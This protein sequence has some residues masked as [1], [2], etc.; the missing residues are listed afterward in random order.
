MRKQE[1]LADSAKILPLDLIC[2]PAVRFPIGLGTGVQQR[3]VRNIDTVRQVG[4]HEQKSVFDLLGV[5]RSG[6]CNFAELDGWS[7][8]WPNPG[9]ISYGII[10][11]SE[12]HLK[13]EFLLLVHASAAHRLGGV[14]FGARRA[15][16][17]G[18]ELKPLH[19]RKSGPPG[20]PHSIRKAGFLKA[21]CAARSRLG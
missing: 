4:W 13:S 16:V 6:D 14:R 3:V 12:L 9:R 21:F 10:R 11:R 18:Y 1:L 20:F 17:G 2:A 15:F 5:Q 19:L 7:A 8:V